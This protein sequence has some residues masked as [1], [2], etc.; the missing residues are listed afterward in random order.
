MVNISTSPDKIGFNE[1]LEA[2]IKGLGDQS[3]WRGG[4]GYEMK[5]EGNKLHVHVMDKYSIASGVSR[6]DSDN[7]KRGDSPTPLGTTTMN[8]YF[9]YEW[10]D[11]PKNLGLKKQKIDSKVKSIK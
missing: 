4:M 6:N 3:F 7:I 8:V 2:H 5:L 9:N 10:I 1:S 11:N